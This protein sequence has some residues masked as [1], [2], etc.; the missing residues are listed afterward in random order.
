MAKGIY[1]FPLFLLL[2]APF[3]FPFA[4]EF[5]VEDDIFH[6][7]Y[8][9]SFSGGF[10]GACING[11]DGECNDTCKNVDHQEFGECQWYYLSPILY[12]CDE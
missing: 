10:H 1:V 6:P 4:S 12:K 5:Y 7:G 8:C 11:R 9:S 2:T 3:A